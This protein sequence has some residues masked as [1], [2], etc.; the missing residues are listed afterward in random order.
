MKRQILIWVAFVVLALSV[1]APAFAHHQ[2]EL[3]NL[4]EKVRQQAERISQLE[5][6]VLDLNARICVLETEPAG[7]EPGEGCPS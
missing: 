5:S 4:K 7:P 2:P 3:G 6:Y 1:A